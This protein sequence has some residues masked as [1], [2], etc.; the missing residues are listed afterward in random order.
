MLGETLIHLKSINHH[1]QHIFN[2][3]RLIYLLLRWRFSNHLGELPREQSCN[4]YYTLWWRRKKG[5]KSHFKSDSNNK[6][7]YHVS[8]KASFFIARVADEGKF[9]STKLSAQNTFNKLLLSL[10]Q[11]YALPLSRLDAVMSRNEDLN[12]KFWWFFFEKN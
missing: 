10:F 11:R 6:N 2:I 9:S 7:I 5:G 8:E 3:F 1:L 4:S 12:D